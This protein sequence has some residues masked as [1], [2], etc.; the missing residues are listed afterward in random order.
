MKD[1]YLSFA[2]PASFCLFLSLS[3][4]IS[5]AQT[6]RDIEG[7]EYQTVQIGNQIWSIENLR[8][9]SFNDSTAIPLVTVDAEWKNRKDPACCYYAN[10]TNSD[11]MRIFGLLYNWYAIDTKKLAPKGWHIPTDAEWKDLEEY[12][13]A[14]GFQ[15]DYVAKALASKTSWK[16]G[17]CDEDTIKVHGAVGNDLSQNNGSGFSA[18]AGGMRIPDG[19]FTVPTILDI[20]PGYQRPYSRLKYIGYLGGWWSATAGSMGA[21]YYRILDYAQSRL[22][23]GKGDRRNGLSVRLIKD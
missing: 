5:E 20:C 21:S 15:R 11:S 17:G 14:N 3:L 6:M 7:N 1:T 9:K 13:I 23:R 2:K 16:T 4:G 19:S 10:T 18:I 8:T 12:L 22:L